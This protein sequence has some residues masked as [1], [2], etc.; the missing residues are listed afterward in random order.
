MPSSSQK[1]RVLIC[2]KTGI[3]KTSLIRAIAGGDVV[4]E[5]AIGHSEP[6][7]RGFCEYEFDD[8]LFVDTEGFEPGK[9]EADYGEFLASADAHVAV[10][11]IDGS[12]ARVQD[13]DCRLLDSESLRGKVI[14]AFTKEDAVR[15]HQRAKL[16]EALPWCIR[17]S[18]CFFSEEDR[19][20]SVGTL[21]KILRGKIREISK[22]LPEEIRRWEE[23][24]PGEIAALCEFRKLNWRQYDAYSEGGGFNERDYAVLCNH[25][26]ETWLRIDFRFWAGR[27][28][29][30]RLRNNVSVLDGSEYR[31]TST[32]TLLWK[33][34]I[35]SS[36]V[37]VVTRKDAENYRRK[38]LE[39]LRDFQ[40]VAKRILCGEPER[41]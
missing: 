25:S 24:R 40:C 5:S 20:K 27:R 33:D 36:C 35:E 23:M 3:G 1:I 21:M 13:F 29:F 6:K 15:E 22:R 11:C 19:K 12:G 17:D 14:V 7:T 9:S 16:T 18:S 26:K 32:E 30:H 2:G 38:K 34:E 39:A 37:K 10:Y 4:L 41:I 28:Y 31:F 8:F